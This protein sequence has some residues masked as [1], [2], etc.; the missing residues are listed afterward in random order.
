MNVNLAALF[1]A[2]IRQLTISTAAVNI[3]ASGP[4]IVNGRGQT[5]VLIQN[6]SSGAIRAGYDNT[7]TIL[8]GGNT[9]ILIAADG[10]QLDRNIG[11]AIAT[12]TAGL[13]VIASSSAALTIEDRV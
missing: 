7:L 10:G 13:W 1:G 2:R 6:N 9:G 5:G 4:Y 8:G 12:S 11:G 3:F